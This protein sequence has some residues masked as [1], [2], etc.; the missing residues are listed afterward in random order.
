MS[1]IEGNIVQ[2]FIVQQ[3]GNYENMK[4]VS[5]FMKFNSITNRISGFQGKLIH[6]YNKNESVLLDTDYEKLIENRSNVIL[7]GDSLGIGDLS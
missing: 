5:N 2:E 7:I 4:I 6:V 1:S 3:C